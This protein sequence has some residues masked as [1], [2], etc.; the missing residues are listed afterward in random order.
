MIP[1]RVLLV[2]ES[3]PLLQRLRTQLEGAE[4][5]EVFSAV[6]P[7]AG[8]LG[9]ARHQPD[10]LV[11][12][13]FTGGGTTEEWKRAILRYRASRPLSVL[14]LTDRLSPHD[15]TQLEA[16]A[17]LGVRERAAGGRL[18]EAIL[19]AWAHQGEPLPEVA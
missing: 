10:L 12:D 1:V 15:Q 3:W 8:M 9:L 4:G 14:V 17:D 16:L 18:L 2:E 6:S 19:M 11:L 7:A 13:P 5:F